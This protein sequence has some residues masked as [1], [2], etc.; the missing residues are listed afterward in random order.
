MVAKPHKSAREDVLKM[1]DS[2][3]EY[4]YIYIYI[5]LF[6]YMYSFKETS[7]Y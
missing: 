3:G 1:I 6:M 7:R 4:V 2:V 5:Y